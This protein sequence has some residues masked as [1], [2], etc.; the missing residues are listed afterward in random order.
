V[1]LALP[2]RV[3]LE[4]LSFQP[5]L[6]LDRQDDLNSVATWMAGHA[7]AIAIYERP[8]WREAGLSGDVISQLGPLSEI[9]DASAKDQK[10]YALFGFLS[11]P[12]KHRLGRESQIKQEIVGQLS[13][14][15]GSAAAKPLDLLY[16]DW[17]VDNLVATTLDQSLPNHHP[18]NN[19]KTTTDWQ[20]SLIWS[21]SEAAQGPYNG[22]IEGALVASEQAL[23]HLDSNTE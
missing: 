14:L 4:T 7:K 17:A 20:A 11:V 12:A 9:H 10:L 18:L 13:R 8:F 1:V 21:G 3:A 22:Y 19:W 23:A 6:A 5:E 15:F 2:A 16:K